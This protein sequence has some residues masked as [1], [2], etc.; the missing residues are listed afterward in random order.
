ML[1]NRND[2][3]ESRNFV[4]NVNFSAADPCIWVVYPGGA[5]GDLL[6]SIIDKHYLRTGCEYYGIDD[7]GRVKLYTTD[8]ET[9]DNNHQITGQ[10]LFND[11]WFFDLA[12][13]LGE[14]NLNYSLLDQVIFG[15][16]LYPPSYINNILKTFPQSKIINIYPKDKKGLN[17]IKILGSYK[18][19]N[20]LDLSVLNES[21]DYQPNLVEHE[22]VLNVPFGSLFNDILY[23]KQ[24]NM[25]LNFLELPG[26]LISF[27]Y[28]KFYL[29]KQHPEIKNL[30]T[31]YSES[32]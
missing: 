30:L 3:L 17:L 21:D 4:D 11:Q 22:R 26:Q 27:D 10:T 32:L 14:R 5:S 24:Y 19:K 16:H 9:I 29:S 25:I 6:I 28:I 13:K 2:N 15:C 1:C 20:L 18:N 7:S 31:E 12:E 23:H 8:Y